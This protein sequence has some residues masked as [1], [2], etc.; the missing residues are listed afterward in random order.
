M[1][2]RFLKQSATILDML[3]ER[4]QLNRELATVALKYTSRI[5]D[6]RKDGHVITVQHLGQ[7]LT[8]YALADQAK[9]ERA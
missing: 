7:G 4:P 5:S 2:T 9:K 6:L 1:T 3:R 8:R